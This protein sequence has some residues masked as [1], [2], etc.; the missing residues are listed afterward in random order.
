M[1]DKSGWTSGALLKEGARLLEQYDLVET[2]EAK[3]QINGCFL[4]VQQVLL[5]KRTDGQNDIKKR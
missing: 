3:D 5:A 4:A 2:Q 1:L